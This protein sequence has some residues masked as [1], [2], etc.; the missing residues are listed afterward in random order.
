[1][2]SSHHNPIPSPGRGHGTEIPASRI[3]DH[4][5]KWAFSLKYWRQITNFALSELKAQHL[6]DLLESLRE[7]EALLEKLFDGDGGTKA[8]M[9]FHP[10]IWEKAKVPIKRSDLDWLP[11]PI[12]SNESEYPIY[13]FTIL[14]GALRIAGFRPTNS[15]QFCVV[16]IDPHHNLHV[17]RGYEKATDCYSA[18]GA[19]QNFLVQLRK[20]QADLSVEGKC[21]ADCQARSRILEMDREYA[22]SAQLH[23]DPMLYERARQLV[24]DRKVGRVEDVF[25]HGLCH[26]ES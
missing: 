16:L 8:L 11:S 6:I 3:P 1:M 4:Q 13:Q 22:Y 15:H 2:L 17:S 20:L 25:E 5:A 21:A 12:L 14:D 10:V 7:G 18:P 19:Y 24:A 26:L 9:H 23:V